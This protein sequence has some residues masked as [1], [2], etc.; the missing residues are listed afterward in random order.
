MRI[1]IIAIFIC[2]L[3]LIV[4]LTGCNEQDE[5]VNLEED[6]FIGTWV[7]SKDY[8]G[9]I[10]TITYIFSSDKNVLFKASYK[11]DEIINTGTW[12]ID[13]N[14]LVINVNNN[15]AFIRYSFYDDN[16]VLE[17]ADSSGNSNILIK[18]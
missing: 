6:K 10:R 14:K 3:L 11:D 15:Q 17:I 16:N 1:N 18:Q 12:K 4:G 9:S 8:E 7:E 13:L 5:Q 2:I